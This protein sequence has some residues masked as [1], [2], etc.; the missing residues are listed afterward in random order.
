MEG[1]TSTSP[2]DSP[3]VHDPILDV[4]LKRLLEEREYLLASGVYYEDDELIVDLD[5]EIQRLR[6]AI[7][8]AA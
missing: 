7:T 1:V 4:H 6:V 8:N 2:G 3:N 5:K